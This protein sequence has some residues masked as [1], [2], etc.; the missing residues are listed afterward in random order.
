MLQLNSQIP[1]HDRPPPFHLVITAKRVLPEPV[2]ESPHCATPYFVEGSDDEDSTEHRPHKPDISG[3]PSPRPNTEPTNPVSLQPRQLVT[4][5]GWLSLPVVHVHVVVER[6]IG[7]DAFSD[8]PLGCPTKQTMSIISSAPTVSPTTHTR[9][10]WLISFR[11]RRILPIVPP[12]FRC[13]GG[14]LALGR[15]QCDRVDR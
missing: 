14:R 1:V 5:Y 7:R 4:R 9:L 8:R 2:V 10:T 6:P 13:W 15:V 11:D 12:P 3:V